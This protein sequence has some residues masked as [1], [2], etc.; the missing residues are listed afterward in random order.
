MQACV[1]NN[2][3]FPKIPSGSLLKSCVIQMCKQLYGRGKL[4]CQEN[5]V[6]HSLTPM[7]SKSRS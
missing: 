1:I 7:L 4:G 5:R 2:L 6:I 3:I